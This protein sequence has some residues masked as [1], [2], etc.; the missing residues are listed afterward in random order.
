MLIFKLLCFQHF[1]GK[2]T[3]DKTA[4]A[5]M[6]DKQSL[7]GH[8]SCNG[9]DDLRQMEITGVLYS[10]YSNKRSSPSPASSQECIQRELR[11]ARGQ[12][13][14]KYWNARRHVLSS[15]SQLSHEKNS[16][17]LAMMRQTVL[18]TSSRHIGA[19]ETTKLEPCLP[20]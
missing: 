19:K 8:S 20:S 4:E 6:Y 13:K 18:L 16:G 15:G 12:G 9:A 5:N 2:G 14:K 3:K 11:L 1:R 17:S 10:D 7:K